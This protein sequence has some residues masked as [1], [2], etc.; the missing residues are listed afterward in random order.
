MF[1]TVVDRVVNLTFL[2]LALIII[3]T[4]LNTTS[5][6]TQSK[7]IDGKIELYREESKKVMM[8]N[9]LYL[10]GRLNRYS[11]QQDS[12]QNSTDQRVNILE[13]QIKLIQADKKLNQRIVNNNVNNSSA[14]VNER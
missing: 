9:L 14:V 13:A 10:E 4:L 3:T 6:S 2:L 11:S 8:N 1:W 7:N 12:Y 5:D